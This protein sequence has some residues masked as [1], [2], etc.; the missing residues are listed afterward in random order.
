MTKQTV[1]LLTFH[2]DFQKVTKICPEAGPSPPDPHSFRW[3][4][5]PPLRPRL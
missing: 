5:A 2:W 3:L 4:G 1:V